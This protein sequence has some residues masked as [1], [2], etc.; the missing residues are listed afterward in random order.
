MLEDLDIT[1]RRQSKKIGARIALFTQAS[2]RL[3]LHRAGELEKKSPTMLRS[4]TGG[5]R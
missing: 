4:S 3:C 5:K 1:L 2:C